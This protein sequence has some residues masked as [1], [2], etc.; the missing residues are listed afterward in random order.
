M[1]AHHRSGCLIFVLLLGACCE[2]KPACLYAE[3]RPAAAA[4]DLDQR[5]MAA[6]R[7]V[8][9]GFAESLKFVRRNGERDDECTLVEEPVMYF[10]DPVYHPEIGEGTMWIWKCE[11]R[12]QVIAE[13][14]NWGPKE[15]WTTGLYSFANGRLLIRDGD[16]L[17]RELRPTDFRPQKIP[18]A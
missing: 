13:V 15:N 11:G 5:T 7:K 4:D 8:M 9:R 2:T 1:S 14:Y 6:R 17:R 18:D 16:G 3:E 12:P 10:S